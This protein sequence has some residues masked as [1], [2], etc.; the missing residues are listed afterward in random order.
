MKKN[1]SAKIGIAEPTIQKTMKVLLSPEQHATVTFAAN[2]KG[3]RVGAYMQKIVME[4]AE[5]DFK[6]KVKGA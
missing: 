5:K 6:E 2:S 3:M 1:V 4:Q